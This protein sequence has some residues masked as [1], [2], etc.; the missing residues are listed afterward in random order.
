MFA[1]WRYSMLATVATRPLRSGQLMRSTAV[2]F[3]GVKKSGYPFTCGNALPQRLGRGS[4][5]LRCFADRGSEFVAGAELAGQQIADHGE[6]GAKS[7]QAVLALQ[8]MTPC[9]P[10]FRGFGLFDSHSTY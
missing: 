8:V 5:A 6:T 7:G 10:R 1:P 9:A 3:M 4:V 2:F